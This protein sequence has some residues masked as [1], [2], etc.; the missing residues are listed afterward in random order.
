MIS[1][2]GA[3]NIYQLYYNIVFTTSYCTRHVITFWIF[4]SRHHPPLGYFKEEYR[5]S[6]SPSHNTTVRLLISLIHD[7]TVY[8]GCF[9]FA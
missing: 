5:P 7:T 6:T 2:V 9:L 8:N 1:S 3:Y 4:K